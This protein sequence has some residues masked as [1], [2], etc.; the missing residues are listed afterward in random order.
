MLNGVDESSAD[1]LHQAAFWVDYRALSGK[2]SLGV[3][4]RVEVGESVARSGSARWSPR[5]SARLDAGPQL[6]LSVGYGRT[7][8]YAQAVANAGRPVGPQWHYGQVWA[9]AG[10]RVPAA[11]TDLASLGVEYWWLSGATLRATGWLRR[12]GGLI[13]PNPNAGEVQ[14][15]ILVYEPDTWV[16]AENRAIGLDVAV[17]SPAGRRVGGSIAYSA[18]LSAMTAGDLR[19][20]S[21][22]ERRHTLNA[23]G[24]V[25][26][27]DG[28]LVGSGVTVA[29]GWPF[30]RVFNQVC[31][32][33]DGTGRC[34]LDPDAPDYRGEPFEARA[35]GYGS[36]DLFLDWTHD[37]PGVRWGLRAQ[38]RNV[39]GIDNQAAYGDT[40]CLDTTIAISQCPN[41]ERVS[42]RFSPGLT[43]LVP[44]ISF[45]AHF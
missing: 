44:S 40:L 26:V 37:G 27:S 36:L 19:F 32:D 3:G 14:Q 18:L 35:P 13:V 31:G 4:G 5:L 1:A 29:A 30:S 42:D 16:A 12:I 43:G 41:S 22:A 21:P 9:T 20:A 45:R 15:R 11:K 8:Q 28:L 38:L 33:D 23:L 17:R 34:L 10:E 2:W 25:R 39:L 7:Y 6:R 24:E